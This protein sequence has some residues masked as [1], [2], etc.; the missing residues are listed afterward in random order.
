V[1]DL[2]NLILTHMGGGRYEGTY[3]GFS[4]EGTYE[5][6]VH[7]MDQD[8]NVSLPAETTVTQAVV[9]E[10]CKECIGDKVELAGVTFITGTNCE[11]TAATS[12]TI[13][14]G[15]KIESGAN[16]TFRAPS[17]KVLSGFEAVQGA[18]VR[19]KQE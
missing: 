7:A 1:T 12:I 19:I 17:V 11:C 4:S 5:V 9:L 10:T 6:A 3:N 13:G 8:G 16:I 2:P 15:V 14:P 18:V